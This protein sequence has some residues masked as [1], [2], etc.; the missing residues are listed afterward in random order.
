M[1]TR[2]YSAKMW[3][4]YQLCHSYMINR[5]DNSP[6]KPQCILHL[7]TFV[8]NVQFVKIAVCNFRTYTFTLY[9]MFIPILY[10]H[11]CPYN[12]V[13]ITFKFSVCQNCCIQFCTYISIFITAYHFYL[14]ILHLYIIYPHNLVTITRSDIF[15]HIHT[16]ITS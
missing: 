14:S 5:S 10:L 13:T 3:L 8:H 9:T 11:K 15:T 2:P 6:F 16:F 12:L 7:Q 1:S 4:F